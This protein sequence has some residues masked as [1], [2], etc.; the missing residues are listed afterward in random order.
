MKTKSKLIDAYVRA[1]RAEISLFNAIFPD[2]K[3]TAQ[4]VINKLS[5]KK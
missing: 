3:I 4:D 5:I 2:A 1:I